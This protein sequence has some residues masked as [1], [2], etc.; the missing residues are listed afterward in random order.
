MIE[1]MGL[2]AV[3]TLNPKQHTTIKIVYIRFSEALFKLF[4]LNLFDLY[5]YCIYSIKSLHE[6]NVK[7]AK[8]TSW[9]FIDAFE[10]PGPRAPQWLS[11]LERRTYKQY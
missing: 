4:Y 6:V 7:V 5:V 1:R 9:R 3:K 11:R 8:T 10:D 2:V